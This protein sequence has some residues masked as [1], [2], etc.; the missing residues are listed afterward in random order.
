MLIRNDVLQGGKVVEGTSGKIMK[1][2][3]L[4]ILGVVPD[5]VIKPLIEPVKS[6]VIATDDDTTQTTKN[7]PVLSDGDQGQER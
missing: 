6:D 4:D 2:S 3:R 1:P 5:P 7:V